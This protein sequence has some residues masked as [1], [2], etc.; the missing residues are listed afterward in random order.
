MGAGREM[1]TSEPQE[2][3]PRPSARSEP[4][5]PPLLKPIPARFSQ[6]THR[7]LDSEIAKILFP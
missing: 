7:S 5:S 3:Y 2:T 6:R 4:P 1:I